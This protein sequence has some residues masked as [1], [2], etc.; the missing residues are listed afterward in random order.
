MKLFVL[1]LA[2]GIPG[3]VWVVAISV[4]IAASVG[5]DAPRLV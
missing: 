4:I 3:A 5:A 2:L 1:R